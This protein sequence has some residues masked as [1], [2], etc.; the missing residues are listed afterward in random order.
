MKSEEHFPAGH[1]INMEDGIV[2]PMGLQISPCQNAW[3][4]RMVMGGN[5]GQLK[6][7]LVGI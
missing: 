3:L 2:T 1:S 7:I 6:M 4:S 5:S